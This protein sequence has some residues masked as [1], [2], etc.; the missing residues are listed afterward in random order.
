MRRG[1]EG[2][3]NLPKI[4]V[5]GLTWYQEA[6]NFIPVLMKLNTPFPSIHP[7]ELQVPLCNFIL[8]PATPALFSPWRL[9]TLT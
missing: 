4:T 3:S 8:S 1:S 9:F 5:S 2:L 7:L 6:G